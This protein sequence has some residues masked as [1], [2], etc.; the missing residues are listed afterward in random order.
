MFLTNAR[1]KLK[2]AIFFVR[3][4]SSLSTLLRFG[5]IFGEF[6]WPSAWGNIQEGGGEGGQ[7]CFPYSYKSNPPLLPRDDNKDQW[8]PYN[9]LN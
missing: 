6:R 3:C 1:F 8:N 2:N 4:K 9:S 7:V 5:I